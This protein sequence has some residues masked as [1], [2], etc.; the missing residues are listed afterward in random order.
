[1]VYERLA[2]MLNQEVVRHEFEQVLVG[3]GLSLDEAKEGVR[4]IV[5]GIRK[6][7][8]ESGIAPNPTSGQPPRPGG[9]TDA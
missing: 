3:R 1:M 5:E 9:R 6:K 7:P 4:L 2:D 8:V